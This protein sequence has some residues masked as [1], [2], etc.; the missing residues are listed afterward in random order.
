MFKG[1]KIKKSDGNTGAKSA[2]EENI[3][4]LVMGGVVVSGTYPTLGVSKQ[5]IQPSDAD[6]LG[7]TA[8]YDANNKVLVRYHIDEF[9]RLNANGKLWIMIVAQTTTM[10][11]MC[12]KA[13]PNVAKLLA[14]SGYKIKSY[15][16]VRNPASGYVATITNGIDV[17]VTNA[18]VKAQDLADDCVDRNVPVDWA[19][20]EGRELGVTASDW[21]DLRTMGSPNSFV[22]VLQDKDI[23]NLDALYAKT[24]AVGTVLGGLGI[25]RTEEDLGCLPCENQPDKSKE[26]YP[27]NDAAAGRWLNPA[28]SSGVLTKNLSSADV[29]ALVEKGYIFADEY[30]QYEGVYFS[31]SSACTDLGSD[32]AYGVNTRVW[33]QAARIAIKKLTPKFNSKVM[34]VD[35]KIAVPTISGWESDVNFGKGGL[36]T[37]VTGGNATKAVTFIDPNQDVQ[38]DSKLKVKMSVRPYSYSRDIEGEI[39]LS[40]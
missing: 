5:L 33:N 3:Y 26:T 18:V 35:G 2:S 23:A 11:Q 39:G 20:I 14:D 19:V 40:R 37:M 29:T 30:P 27:I 21:K 4:G 31:G 9:F 12:D 36:N 38:A 16:V 17:D 28:I 13:L 22:A 8:A 6:A 34:T 24:A 32:F 1:P 10:A 25:R 7:F 15:G